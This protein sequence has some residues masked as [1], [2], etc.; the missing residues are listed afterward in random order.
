M[1]R[2]SNRWAKAA[3]LGALLIAVFV[4]GTRVVLGGMGI[5]GMGIQGMGIQGMGIQGMG[6]QGMGIQGMGIQGMGIQGMGIQG[7]GIQGMGIQGMGIQGMGI[8]GMG[9][10][11]MGIQGMGIQGMGIQGMG[12]QGMGIQGMGIQ[13]TSLQGMQLRGID[14]MRTTLSYVEFRG[15]SRADVTFSGPTLQGLQAGTLPFTSIASPMNQVKL[16][17][18]PGTDTG[19]GSYIY[20][21]DLPPTI[22]SLKG[23][24]WNIV[25]ADTCNTNQDCTGAAACTDG[26]CTKVCADDTQ[27]SSP[28]KCVQ[29]SCSD[30][31]GAI[32]LY[33]SDVE[34]DRQFNTSKYPANDDIFLYTVYYRNPATAQ[35]MSLCPL[36]P[37][38]KPHAMAVPLNPTDHGDTGRTKFTFACTA[39]GVAAKCARVWGY[40]PWKTV[41]ENLIVNGTPVGEQPVD[42]AP[43][44]DACLIAARAD[45]CQDGRSFTKN[46]TTVDLFDS[47]DG[48]T[49]INA[50]AGLPYAPNSTGTM[51][52][53]EYEISSANHVFT[54]D[55]VNG[56]TIEPD[57]TLSAA[58]LLSGM[59]SSRYADLDPGR[60]CFAAP[61]IDRCDPKEPY[62]CYRTANMGSRP[63]GAFIA[64]NSPRHCAH[65]EMTDGPA[66]D[67]L[68]N[69]CV[70]RIC[71][72]DPTCCG[73]PGPGFYPGSLVWDN[74][75][76]KLHDQV[77][78]SAPFDPTLPADD[79]YNKPWNLGAVAEPAG[80]H[81]AVFLSGTIGSFEQ[82]VGGGTTNSVAEGWA[83]DPDYP[84]ASVPV[85]LSVGGPLGSGTSVITAVADQPLVPAWRAAAAA[86]C[87]GDG[88][89]GFRITVAPGQTLYAYGIDLNVPGAPFSLLRGGGKT[90]PGPTLAAP[91]AALWTGWL[92]PA[93][94]GNY[95]FCKQQSGTTCVPMPVPV[96]P[97]SGDRYRVWV[98]GF[99]VAGNW[100]DGTFTLPPPDPFSLYLQSGVRYGVRVEYLTAA[101]SSFGLLWSSDFGA[102]YSAIPSNLFQP[103]AP[104]SGNGLLG[105]YYSTT[106]FSGPVAD[107]V[108][109]DVLDKVWTTG[110]PPTTQVTIG[111]G[112]SATFE[113]QVEPPIPGD[114]TFTADTDGSVKIFV[115]G[116][117]V[118]DASRRPPGAGNPNLCPHDICQTGAAISRTCDQGY[119]C[120]AQICIRDPAC[121][122]IT[123]DQVCVR[124]VADICNL[125]C[126]PTPPIAITL[127]AGVK[128]DIRVEY[129]HGLGNGAALHLKWTIP[130]AAP[131]VIPAERLF[132]ARDVSGAQP[133]VGLNAAYFS[134]VGFTAQSEYLDHVEPSPSYTSGSAPGVV[135]AQSIICGAG[136]TDTGDVVGPPA[137]TQPVAGTIVAGPAVEIDGLGAGAGAS[138]TV[139]EN[140]KQGTQTLG[141]AVASSSGTFSVNVPSLANGEYTVTAVQT[142]GSRTSVASAPLTFKVGTPI[143][144]NAPGPPSVDQPPGGLVTTNGQ[145]AI[146]G[147]GVTGAQVTV[148][149]G[150]A[151]LGTF[152]VVNG[153]WSGYVT[154]GDPGNYTLSVTQTV[155]N[156]TSTAGP[157]ITARRT[158]PPLTVD[159]PTDGPVDDPTI[160]IAGSAPTGFGPVVVGDGDGRSFAD[161]AS[162]PLDGNAFSGSLKLDYGTHVLKFFQ[163]TGTLDGDGVI[164]TI[165]VRPPHDALAIKTIVSPTDGELDV[166][167]P[168]TVDQHVNV[169]GTGGLPLTA[170]RGSVRVYEGNTK[171]GEGPLADD[172]SFNVP[173]LLTGV[174]DQTLTVTQVALSLSGGGPAESLSSPSIMVKVRPPQPVITSPQTGSQQTELDVDVQ[175]TAL[176]GATVTIAVDGKD[177]VTVTAQ[178]GTDPLRPDLGTFEQTLTLV[179]G[180]HRLTAYQAVDSTRGQDSAS[181]VIAVGDITPPTIEIVRA[182]CA[183]ARDSDPTVQCPAVRELLLPEAGD[184]AVDD[185]GT[186]VN[187]ADKVR[188]SATDQGS[189]LP[190][191][192]LPS[193]TATA[194]FALGSSSVTCDAIDAA[195]NRGSST[196]IVTV[197]SGTG[198]SIADGSVT[199]EALGP[200][201]AAVNFPLAATGWVADCAPPGAPEF[202]PCT[203]WKPTDKGLGFEP[204]AV[205]LNTH[206]GNVYTAFVGSIKDQ[207]TFGSFLTSMDHGA[208]WSIQAPPSAAPPNQILWV[209]SATPTLYIPTYLNGIRI[210]SD[211]GASWTGALAGID[212]N[213]VAADP[214]DPKH[215]FAWTALNGGQTVHFASML[216]ETHD[217]WATWATVGEGLPNGVD[218]NGVGLPETQITGMVIDPIDP[219]RMYIALPRK[220]DVDGNPSIVQ[221]YRKVGQEQ[222]WSRLPIPPDPPIGFESVGIQIAPWVMPC[223]P[224]V[225]PKCP[226]HPTVYVDDLMS[227]DGGDSWVQTP[228]P[229]PSGTESLGFDRVTPGVVYACTKDGILQSQNYGRTWTVRNTTQ[230]ARSLVQDVQQPDTWY[231]IGLIGLYKSTDAAATWTEMRAPELSLG[232]TY[233]TDLAVD[234]TN[235]KVAYVL[236]AA[237]GV[238]KTIDGA[239]SWQA[240]GLGNLNSFFL[241]Q[242]QFDPFNASTIY[243]SGGG[244]LAP[245]VYETFDGS[246][247][248]GWTRLNVGGALAI[249]PRNRDTLYSAQESNV[250][251]GF[252]SF[253][254]RYSAGVPRGYRG[255]G[256]ND[257]GPIMLPYRFQVAPDAALTGIVSWIGDTSTG[258]PPSA[259]TL[260]ISIA[261]A[262]HS[263]SDA[264]VVDVADTLTNVQYDGS[265]GIDTLFRGGANGTDSSYLYRAP[266]AAGVS[267]GASD[268]TWTLVG[269]GPSM[270]GGVSFTDFSRL[271]ID[272]A[273]A[274]RTLYTI[275]FG[276]SMWQSHDGGQTWQQD[277]AAPS[278]IM[279]LWLSPADGALYAN[280]RGS[281][282]TAQERQDLLTDAQTNPSGTIWKRTLT[283]GTPP[284]ARV[285]QGDVRVTCTDSSGRV[286]NPGSPFPIGTTD[287]TCTATD[288]FN[289][290]AQRTIHITVRDST[291]PTIFVP[292]SALAFGT[293]P[294]E[295]DYQVS[296]TDDIDG[297][298]T[299]TCDPASG[300]VFNPGVTTVNC[301]AKDKAGNVGHASFPAI[302]ANS[303]PTITVPGD[304]PADAT[305]PDGALVTYPPAFAHD[306]LNQSIPVNCLPASGSQFPLG[307]T[308]VACT[309]TDSTSGTDVTASRSFNVIVRDNTPPSIILPTLDPVSA[310]GAQ[311]APVDYTVTAKDAVAGPVPVECVPPPKSTFPLGATTVVCR[312][313]D[314]SGN[315]AIAQFDITVADFNPPV[316][317]LADVHA[318]A[319]DQT[320][321]RVAFKATATDLEDGPIVPDCLPPSGSWFPMHDTTVVCTAADSAHNQTRGEFVVH[322]AD[323]TPPTI[324]ATDITVEADSPDG[325]AVKLPTSATDAVDGPAT[326]APT[327]TRVGGLAAPTPVASGATFPLGEST[328]TC[329]STDAAGNIGSVT[330]TVLV[331]D[332]TAP[333][334]HLP[335]LVTAAADASGTALVTF[336]ATA[337]DIVSLALPVSCTPKPGSRF[338]PGTTIV[339]CSA[340]D[341]AGNEAQ[342]N[343]P[344]VVTTGDRR[345][346][347]CSDT[348]S[349]GGTLVCV[350]GVCCENDCGKG[351]TNDCVA[352]SVAAGGTLNGTCTP[353]Q[354]GHVCRAAAGACDL[355]ET[356]NGTDPACPAD[357]LATEGT[358]C[359]NS[360]GPCDV[361]EA[362]NG[363]SAACPADAFAPPTQ[364]CRRAVD[365]CDVAETCTGSSAACPPDVF[366]PP[367][368][369]CRPSTGACDPAEVCTGTSGSC[370]PDVLAPST[371]ICR[372]GTGACDPAEAC[373]GTSGS[374]PADVLAPPTQVC[375]PS[376]GACDPAESCTGTSG[377]CPADVL[378]PPTQICRPA[379]GAC[380][381]AE[382]CT[383]ASAACPADALVPAGTVCA[384]A[385]STCQSPGICNGTVATCPAPTPI[386]GCKTDTTPPVWTNVPG[387]I[388]AY[389][390]CN[391]GATVTYTKPT[392]TDAVDGVRPVTCLPASGTMFGP[393]KNT[394]TCTASDKSS[395]SS[396]VSFTIWVKVQAPM[397]GT[398]FL[399]PINPD[400]SSI[401][402]MGS[403]V[404]VKFALQGA[405]AGITNLVAHLTTAKVT[406]NITGTYTEPV[407]TAASDSGNTFRYDSSAKQYIFNLSTKKMATGT[408][409]L[410]VDLGDM[411][412]HVVQ[413]SL[414]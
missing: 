157:D 344:V 221:V 58:L 54:S 184:P 340:R 390:T 213:G 402:K 351:A 86:A 342:G 219:T 375:R 401:F 33:I 274:G 101:G 252:W 68:C 341:G 77:C 331:R 276:D 87:G 320:G 287:L 161:R 160:Q 257:D 156:D 313:A 43:L 97:S 229:S 286:V 385:P 304:T 181:V 36:D 231:A 204:T 46:G 299:P 85:Q 135:R 120:S 222:Q 134:D 138:V 289:N 132:A 366:A 397:D 224:Q 176:P 372:P 285:F 238:F 24:F 144:P 171:V 233:A 201:G 22:S 75:C 237:G 244:R 264:V 255:S 280:V 5:Q 100:T 174:G 343:F 106:D 40:K 3:F 278:Y 193:A 203:S 388:V 315:R 163:R 4:V 179:A 398:F 110:Q 414:K 124:E 251:D 115:N 64:V 253:L 254:T 248:I 80:Q 317:T 92:Q 382:T 297:P 411:V 196:F 220:A 357:A 391:Q 324:N 413:I 198:P 20:V 185:G 10:Q 376:A 109:V 256:L 95:M 387:T 37:Y 202:V 362:C 8:Q 149:L 98:N 118:T 316:L 394:V 408:W 373:T 107:Q 108:V 159:Q 170:Q 142:V 102:S 243:A 232:S 410:H 29:G 93:V 28:A 247:P 53:E 308:P 349:C 192:C 223:D 393:G 227:T 69:E 270:N 294:T 152:A 158:L 404:P 405:S 383:G 188:I 277:G 48:V 139:Y 205:A 175:G 246:G 105:T 126:S 39:S 302:V 334:L 84:G 79:P 399:Q 146:G 379:A 189:S 44:Y 186:S 329:T 370:P 99:Y 59:Q 125:D 298:I 318:E 169:K 164:R 122:S 30:V 65:D 155:G 291:P 153:V 335:A 17:H 178:P 242:L 365:V 339:N 395:N 121:C 307:I 359:R 116:Q 218:A 21:S 292:Q 311:G 245:N 195:N 356:C 129:A 35:W 136:C 128:Y 63:Y 57:H 354:A 266:L 66:L 208:T 96:N 104:G 268:L 412:D 281:P 319:Q 301:S 16:Q 191:T 9:I 12:I 52:H 273:S 1:G 212:I 267:S 32:P 381:V 26:V 119:F 74:R 358:T 400:G 51:L 261:D 314:P 321:A 389:A 167:P 290:T 361:A 166:S 18:G 279:Q 360:A 275:G 211:E 303:W 325:V 322:V 323:T 113:G 392:A 346:Q 89:H 182:D 145:L 250:S 367:A 38:G 187:L 197:R 23:T 305:G 310:L 369:I 309:A 210:S 123:W 293:D 348:P 206:N 249:D 143:D 150:D 296:A 272:P 258:N 396:S 368:Q 350:D 241:H 288:V 130:G 363:S 15:V 262:V 27:C 403:T 94:S 263:G 91:R 300:S 137:L 336:S 355:A 225:D 306:G 103:A 217:G 78:R 112:F 90:V 226:S 259:G 62:A 199:V 230:L 260:L 409:S 312:A 147:T 235:A 326:P 374:C 55:Y 13:A 71:Q 7:M 168:P 332:T 283:A 42:L 209:D 190:V 352:C 236:S 34:V 269:G 67:P 271:I 127:S 25:L 172:G 282:T 177:Q 141:S 406:N 386:P 215:M 2:R 216:F 47:V 41:N 76:S 239:D 117:L 328:V 81:P 194:H 371:Q 88:R 333:T 338:V 148:K 162:L 11:G 56:I 31:E 165:A 140:T 151:T 173:A 83:C 384:P 49:S 183:L 6:I 337:D 131:D 200:D 60:S 295:L 380:D 345:G 207:T 347:P 70:N 154:L 45:Y 82:I 265:D 240:A 234:P 214:Q 364:I 61:H 73:D 72:L 284:G 228:Y 327:C 114:Y 353:I 133:G 330:F 377:S 407:S 50:T 14:R 19:P 111:N 378:S 180:S